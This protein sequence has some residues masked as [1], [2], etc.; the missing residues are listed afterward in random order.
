MNAYA[1]LKP[2]PTALAR[3]TLDLIVQ[4]TGTIERVKR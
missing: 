4:D 2:Q 3:T 1:P